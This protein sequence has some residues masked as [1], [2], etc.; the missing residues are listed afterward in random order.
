[1][2]RSRP[3]VIGTERSNDSDSDERND[4]SSNVHLGSFFFLLFFRFEEVG[5]GAEL[6]VEV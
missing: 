5:V 4:G 6:E 2:T 1:M 3:T